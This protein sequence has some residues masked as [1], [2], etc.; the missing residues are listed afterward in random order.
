MK[1]SLT[2]LLAAILAAALAMTCIAALFLVWDAVVDLRRSLAAERLTAADR[3]M[4][5]T[6][7]VVRGQRTQPQSS[8]ISADSPR[9]AIEAVRT[10]VG[11]NVETALQAVRSAAL[12]GSAALAR[13]IGERWAALAPTFAPIFAESEK[14]RG[15]RTIE[16]GDAWYRGVTALLDTMAAAALAITNETRMSSPLASELIAVRQQAWNLRDY[17]G[18]ECQPGRNN[19][20]AGRPFTV[21]EARVIAGHRGAVD[22]AAQSLRDLLSRADA[23]PQLRQ[24][25]ETAT[26]ALASSRREMDS[27][28]ARLDGSARAQIDVN[29]WNTVCSGQFDR[30]VALGTTALDLARAAVD[31]DVGD[32]R[33]RLGIALALLV[34]TLALA[35]GST[36]LL[37]RRFARPVR[38]LTGA[39][40]ELTSG[41]VANAVPSTGHDDELGRLAAALEQLRQS[42]QRTAALEEAARREADERE[43][44]RVAVDARIAQ[45]NV[46]LEGLIGDNVRLAETMAQTSHQL[47]EASSATTQR[48]GAVAIAS[49]EASSSVQSVA[50]ATEEL[51]AS[52]GEINRQVAH[53]TAIAGRAVGEATATTGTVESL[54]SA[55]DRIGAV[56]DLINQIASQT[57]LL[58]LNATIEA[59]RAGEA[60]KGFAVVASEVKALAG[61][62]AKATEEIAAQVTAIQ[63]ASRGSAT[64]IASIRGTIDEIHRS[65]GSIA[66]AIEQQTA[67]TGEISRNVQA[68]SRATTAT[69]SDIASVNAAADGTAHASSDVRAVS[70]ELKDRAEALR[71]AVAAF[72]AELKAA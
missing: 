56:V 47:S 68:A 63:T 35:G 65:A 20:L 17:A 9:A 33:W 70:T 2:A 29:G 60:G 8:M 25:F 43:R 46:T 31:G 59:A 4:F 23:A 26:A 69:A 66:A 18:R 3:V 41:N 49:G 22:L 58:A 71:Q 55:A 6:M 40:A 13:D 57:N 16:A 42:A 10:T 15:Q 62:T 45:F 11:A 28:Y 38:A 19:V 12:P 67:A 44:R 36:V 64:A 54:A 21:A 1:N 5:E 24:A 48:C 51:T 72:F 37:V 61:Q 30:V 52:I 7:Q 50:A 39:V 53:A 32:A 14:P 27:Y 34:V